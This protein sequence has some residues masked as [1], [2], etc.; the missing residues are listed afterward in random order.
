MIATPVLVVYAAAEC[1]FR[2]APKSRRVSSPLGRHTVT[3]APVCRV[4]N[5]P[6]TGLGAGCPLRN[7][8]IAIR[9]G[10]L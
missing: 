1:P 9:S 4:K 6:C 3:D 7:G 2:L 5:A 8:D 10:A